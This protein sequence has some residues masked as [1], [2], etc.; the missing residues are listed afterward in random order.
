MKPRL[1]IILSIILF[2]TG[3]RAQ[4]IERYVI[5]SAGYSQTGPVSVDC[6]VGEW[7]T[8]T[9]DNGII[10]LT[11]GFQQPSILLAATPPILLTAEIVNKTVVLKW[12]TLFEVNSREM[13]VERGRDTVNAFGVMT[14]VPSSAPNGNS[15]VPLN[16]TWTDIQP[17][18][19]VTY[20][21]IRLIAK[22]GSYIYSN[23]VAI[24]FNPQTWRLEMVYPNPVKTNFRIRLFT[25]EAVKA[26][27]IVTDML[28]R[29]VKKESISFNRGYND[30]LINLPALASGIYIVKIH[31]T[32]ADSPDL[33][34][35]IIKAD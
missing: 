29:I 20:Y 24:L 26:D 11:Q 27:V 6:T 10:I 4:T 30:P 19:S 9:A 33:I 21:R 16:Y 22:D 25:Q 17:L 15:A 14:I 2:A 32:S 31:C 35:R 13:L 8:A 12:T 7:V 3:L 34:A 23:T 18:A 5:G 28:G 1:L